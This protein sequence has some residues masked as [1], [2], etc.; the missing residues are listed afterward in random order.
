MGIAECIIIFSLVI[1]I[2]VTAFNDHKFFEK[3]STIE[4]SLE[5]HREKHK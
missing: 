2:G 5:S 1:Y 4:K 3:C